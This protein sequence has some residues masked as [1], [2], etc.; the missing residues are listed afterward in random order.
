MDNQVRGQENSG[1]ASAAAATVKVD[2]GGSKKQKKRIK[3]DDKLTKEKKQR[4]KEG[5][6]VKIDEVK[7]DVVVPVEDKKVDEIVDT[8]SQEQK[9]IELDMRWRD[10]TCD[11]IMDKENDGLIY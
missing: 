10:H 11:L 1:P 6:K 3:K 5:G 7:Q 8:R 4:P 9:K 2:E